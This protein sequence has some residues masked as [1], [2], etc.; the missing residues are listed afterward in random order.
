MQGVL[1]QES[2]S[3]QEKAAFYYENDEY[4]MARIMYDSILSDNKQDFYSFKQRGN[5]YLNMGNIEKAI[6]DYKN[7][8]AIKPVYADAVF[9]LGNA[10]E[11]LGN[12][13]SA[14]YYF[15]KYI[16]LNP[17][18]ALAYARLS[19][20]KLN[21]GENSDSAVFYAQ[22]SLE[23]EPSNFMAY[24][25][26]SMAYLN[27]DM[28]DASIETALK[29]LE[30]TPEE[31]FILYHPLGLSYY[32]KEDYAKAY[33]YFSQADSMDD[34]G[35]NFIYYKAQSLLMMN[36]REELYETTAKNEIQ[37]KNFNSE[38]LFDLLS[39]TQQKDNHYYYDSLYLKLQKNPTRLSM[40]DFFMLY[41]G[42]A[43]QTSYSPYESLPAEL[44]NFW[45]NGET[46]KYIEEAESI[47]SKNPAMFSLYWNLSVAY[48]SLG[49]KE[50]QFI[51]LYKYY[52]FLQGISATGSGESAKEAIIV[53]KV[54][55]E[56]EI[57]NS[58][59]CQLSSQAL[60]ID[61]KISYDKM[62]CQTPDGQEINVF[63]N[64]HL[65]YS[66]LNNMFNEKGDKKKNRKKR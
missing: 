2:D 12:F 9:N 50:A 47:I 13:D 15:H 65:S 56:Y 3:L 11:S 17:H 20:I 26:L 60:I 18:D 25:A 59:S 42:Y 23:T 57:L 34:F 7:S 55:D 46:K 22:R 39:Q 35:S 31:S 29:G 51:N 48:N 27:K 32:L 66:S 58:W 62:T 8:I 64:I 33:H 38:N 30:Y 24:Y 52:G 40:D 14:T 49:N 37:F 5:C 54:S 4:E 41:L 21:T 28:Y 61:N 10:Y 16:K 44:R 6:V 45:S 63:F 19:L 53:I 1:A 43:K 36:T